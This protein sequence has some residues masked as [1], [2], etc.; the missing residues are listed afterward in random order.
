LN[1]LFNAGLF[2]NNFENESTNG[3]LFILDNNE[4]IAL[5]SIGCKLSLLNNYVAFSLSVNLE[6]F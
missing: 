6:L 1:L 4:F 2:D 5:D 3:S